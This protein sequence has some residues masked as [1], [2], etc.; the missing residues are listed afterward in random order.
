MGIPITIVT[1]EYW[2]MGWG[3]GKGVYENKSQLFFRGDN[4]TI[5]A[6]YYPLI[7]KIKPI[8]WSKEGITSNPL[9]NP[10][11][12]FDDYLQLNLCEKII[13]RPDNS[14]I[15]DLVYPEGG[16][17]RRAR[18]L[19]NNSNSCVNSSE[20]I[21]IN[22][23]YFCPY[24]CYNLLNKDSNLS[25]FG[26]LARDYYINNYSGCLYPCFN[27]PAVSKN[28]GLYLKRVKCL[29]HKCAISCYEMNDPRYN[30][31]ILHRISKNCTNNQSVGEEQ[32]INLEGGNYCNYDCENRYSTQCGP[33][34]F[35]VYYDEWCEDELGN[36]IEMI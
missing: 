8:N 28:R 7:W 26:F 12:Y 35:D 33:L 22:L 20:C 4:I 16:F 5:L 10:F 3:A 30:A 24:E 1:K 13:E 29:N 17:L 14:L 25:N 9:K 27:L 2:N 31:T 21:F 36:Q 34:S 23:S 18:E 11:P 32:I 19:I 6:R 15:E